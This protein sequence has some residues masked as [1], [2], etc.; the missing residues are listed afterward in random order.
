MDSQDFAECTPYVTVKF[1]QRLTR[2]HHISIDELHDAI[3]IGH[4]LTCY[5]TFDGEPDIAAGEHVVT[6]SLLLWLGY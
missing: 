2:D 5:P 1:A 3:G 4:V 6:S